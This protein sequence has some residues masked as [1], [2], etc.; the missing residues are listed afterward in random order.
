[1]TQ[2]IQGCVDRNEMQVRGLQD[3]LPATVHVR[4]ND[5]T[6][7]LGANDVRYALLDS[8]VLG[9]EFERDALR[10][11]LQQADGA[12]DEAAA[13]A[14]FD[15]LEFG[16][17]LELQWNLASALADLHL[18]FISEARAVAVR[19]SV[20]EEHREDIDL[21][22]VAALAQVGL[23][24]GAVPLSDHMA[25]AM[26]V[27]MEAVFT[28]PPGCIGYSSANELVGGTI[29]GLHLVRDGDEI[30]SFTGVIV[31]ALPFGQLR[32]QC[33]M[34]TSVLH[35]ATA[36]AHRVRRPLTL[37]PDFTEA[38]LSEGEMREISSA[39]N[40]HLETQEAQA[41]PAGYAA[42]LAAT[43]FR[44]RLPYW[45]EGGT[46]PPAVA[47]PCTSGMLQPLATCG[48]ISD[49]EKVA[50]MVADEG[51]DE[52]QQ[53]RM[54]R[55]VRNNYYGG[56]ITSALVHTAKQG[57][58]E[59]VVAAVAGAV[60]SGMVHSATASGHCKTK[61]LSTIIGQES[62]A[63]VKAIIEAAL[64]PLPSG[65]VMLGR[66]NINPGPT[67]E[68][69]VVYTVYQSNQ[70]AGSKQGGHGPPPQQ[71][72]KTTKFHLRPGGVLIVS[73]Q[74]NGDSMHEVVSAGGKTLDTVL[75]SHTDKTCVKILHGHGITAEWGLSDGGTE[76]V[77]PAA[78]MLIGLPM[79]FVAATGAATGGRCVVCH[80][81]DADRRASLAVF[82]TDCGGAFPAG[83]R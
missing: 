48:S 34:V 69:E 52:E 77:P 8:L 18:G 79:K 59:P 31:A 28:P 72:R 62:T 80:P 16:G 10:G 3:V 63:A 37:Q 51:G 74:A 76:F 17:L 65:A 61:L 41:S 7:V 57:G 58:S 6:K 60:M 82:V 24:L 64:G 46:C 45:K 47:L 9:A 14:L 55:A 73:G 35:K 70:D 11:R 19:G 38:I 5:T 66:L 15:Q 20:P 33:G 26:K 21:A 2:A 75:T 12:A 13:L 36:R 71:S 32:S 30:R 43:F 67:P 50:E 42:A 49:A 68:G 25:D 54:R 44:T 27:L 83:C 81:D 40:L 1:M 22:R 53:D 23:V 4:P 29:D 56:P 39:V 78:V